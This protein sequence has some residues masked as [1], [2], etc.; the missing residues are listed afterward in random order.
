VDTAP[1]TSNGTLALPVSELRG[2]GPARARAF[3]RIGVRTVRDLLLLM[4]RGASAA[5]A[6]LPIAHALERGPRDG[7]EVTLRGTVERVALQ[8]FGGRS[9]L[10]LTL[11]DSTGSIP[12]LYFNQPWMRK[13]LAL[14][15]EYVLRGRLGGARGVAL[16][17][18]RVGTAEK[19]LAPEGTLQLAYP[20]V[21]GLSAEG[22][23][24]MARALAER[25]AGELTDPLPPELLA[26]HALEPLPVAVRRVHAP[27]SFAEFERARRRLALEPLLALQARLHQRRRTRAS[28]GALEVVLD[29][30]A[31]AELL[32]RLPFALTAGQRAVVEELAADLARGVP[33]RRLLQGDVGTG[34]TV[35]GLWAALAVARAHGQTAFLAPTE[36]LAEQHYEGQKELLRRAGLHAVLLTGSIP[37]PERRTVLAQLESGLA[38]VVFGTHALFSADVRYRRLALAVI[39]EQQRFG[40][41]QRAQLI[42]KG[43]RAHVLLM[44]ATPIPR[45]LA[46]TLY[47][48][49]DTSVLRERPAGRGTVRTR[50]VRGPER[51]RVQAF[52]EERIAAGEQVYWVAPRIGAEVETPDAAGTPE[53]AEEA[54]AERAFA[55]LSAT[56]LA[57]SGL[58]LVHGRLDAAERA[59]RLA[60]FRDGA[61]KLLV[62]TTVI[63]VGV[64]V[65]AATVMVIENAERLG[66]AQLHQLRGRIGRGT[67]D[68]WCLLFGKESASERF[69]V[70][71]RTHDGFEIAEAD[72]RARG[73]G[74]LAGVRQAGENA[75]GL[76]EAGLE[77][78]FLA[79]DLVAGDE[80][81]A[82]AYLGRG[83]ADAAP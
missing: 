9:M 13:Q 35:L 73:M 23:G 75:E 28:T 16:L 68:S 49:L 78:L 39:D 65:P 44:T 52:L 41:A 29:A 15:G 34:K 64:D 55:K 54:S 71:E 4:P 33:M 58:E 62:A 22:V 20:A 67:K 82:T 45:T 79:R 57:K 5:G 48:D 53:H 21:E 17:S 2:V 11:R 3:E 30:P 80:R 6:E 61:A 1:A 12:V 40:V 19:P 25:C 38:D 27:A 47:G 31:R 66:L 70:L 43:E 77:L 14:G 69:R 26:E 46:L 56:P 59:A 72:L 37:G 50:W 32:A 60:R 51:R 7:G 24:R 76:D 36:L 18:P 81:L 42:E 74:D 8:R 10:R 83:R 63:E